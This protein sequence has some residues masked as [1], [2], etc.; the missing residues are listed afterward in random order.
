MGNLQLRSHLQEYVF[1]ENDKTQQWY[2]IYAPFSYRFHILTGPAFRNAKGLNYRW[3]SCVFTPFWDQFQSPCSYIKT[4]RCSPGPL[5]HLE[6]YVA[7][8]CFKIV[9]SCKMQAVTDCITL[10]SF[11]S[12]WLLTLLQRSGFG[13]FYYNI[14]PCRVTVYV[15]LT[16]V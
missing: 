5:I 11:D 16:E 15:W 2:C 6:K 4:F 9:C 13:M 7:E 3:H 14:C 1:I 10:A 8:D 12:T